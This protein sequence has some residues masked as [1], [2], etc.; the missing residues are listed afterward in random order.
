MTIR[1]TADDLEALRPALAGCPDWVTPSSLIAAW[2]DFVSEVEHGYEQPSYEYANEL[3]ARDVIESMLRCAPKE[4][5]E[6]LAAA[7]APLD[8]RFTEAT[9]KV[10]RCLAADCTDRHSWWFRVPLR[11]EAALREDLIAFG[12]IL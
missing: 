1:F 6:R 9:R 2:R 10:E 5:R 4:L 3:G 12:V 8:S 11:L 7:I